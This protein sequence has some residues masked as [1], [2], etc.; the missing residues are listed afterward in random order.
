[1]LIH[2]GKFITEILGLTLINF[3]R[4][5]QNNWKEICVNYVVSNIFG[6]L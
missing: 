1:M 4:F 2:F 5:S 6:I 3:E